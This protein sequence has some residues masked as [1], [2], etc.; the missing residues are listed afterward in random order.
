M[1]KTKLYHLSRT[2]YYYVYPFECNNAVYHGFPNGIYVRAYSMAQAIVYIKR[3]IAIYEN[4][5]YND[6]DID[7]HDITESE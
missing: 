1:S 5:R 6:I 2:K 4:V 7:W 3:R